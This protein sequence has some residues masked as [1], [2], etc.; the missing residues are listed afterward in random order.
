MVVQVR[1]LAVRMTRV[2]MSEQVSMWVTRTG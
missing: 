1:W 2:Q